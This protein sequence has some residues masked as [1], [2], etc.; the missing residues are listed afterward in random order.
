[1]EVNLKLE[2]CPHDTDASHF[3][4]EFNKFNNTRVQMLDSIYH[5]TQ[6]ILISPFLCKGINILQKLNSFRIFPEFMIF[7]LTFLKIMNQADYNSY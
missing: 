5:G 6:I 1:M 3:C 7:R 2:I 4:N